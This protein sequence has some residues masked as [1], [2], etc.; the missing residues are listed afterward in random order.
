MNEE[1]PLIKAIKQKKISQ[2]TNTDPAII[3]SI[4]KTIA[5]ISSICLL[6]QSIEASLENN[7]AKILKFPKEKKTP[8]FNA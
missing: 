7:F 8:F 6:N 5:K 1:H 3:A 2:Q 4:D